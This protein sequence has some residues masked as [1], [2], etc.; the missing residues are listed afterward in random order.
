MSKI[1]N[2]VVKLVFAV[3]YLLAFGFAMLG[4]RE[5]TQYLSD[6]GWFG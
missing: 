4:A 1:K 5:L 6:L 2:M 3:S